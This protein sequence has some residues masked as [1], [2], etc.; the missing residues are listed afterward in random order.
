[1]T[2]TEAGAEGGP[3]EDTGRSHP[4]QAKERGFRRSPPCP[5]LYLRL[6]A[7]RTRRK[8]IYGIEA[9][10]S[11]VCVMATPAINERLKSTVPDPGTHHD[12]TITL[13]GIFPFIGPFL[14]IYIV[15]INIL[16]T[17]I[18]IIYYYFTISSV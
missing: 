8:L 2:G 17:D 16:I 12:I 9:T 6:P 10:Q 18:D 5:Y 13:M 1:M 14:H 15:N 11:M 7:S 4:M 3:H